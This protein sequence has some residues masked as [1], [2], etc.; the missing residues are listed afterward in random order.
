[1]A[2]VSGADSFEAHNL[3]YISDRRSSAFA[4]LSCL[5]LCGICNMCVLTCAC[6]ETERESV[7][8]AWLV[9][10]CYASSIP[11]SYFIFFLITGVITVKEKKKCAL[12][13]EM[14]FSWVVSSSVVGLVPAP[15]VLDWHTTIMFLRIRENT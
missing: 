5:H 9:N 1:M 14:K 6:D 11:R 15:C 8:V 4:E 10:G 12:H 13:Q 3:E 7:H 2:F